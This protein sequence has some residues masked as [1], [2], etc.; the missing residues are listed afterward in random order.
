MDG[1]AV[2]DA[3]AIARHAV[4]S[5][6]NLALFAERGYRMVID[7]RV[8]DFLV[9]DGGLDWASALELAHRAVEEVGGFVSGTRRAREAGSRPGATHEV[10]MIPENAVGIA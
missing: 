10:W 1:S 3:K 4:T 2:T 8:L 7:R 9:V 5:P 6:G